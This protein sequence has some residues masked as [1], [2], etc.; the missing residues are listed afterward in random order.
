MKYLLIAMLGITTAFAQS[1]PVTRIKGDKDTSYKISPNLQVPNKQATKINSTTV[2]IETGNGNIIPDPSFEGSSD[3]NV[4]NWGSTGTAGSTRNFWITSDAY[5]GKKAASLTGYHAPH[6]SSFNVE[7]Y[8]DIDTS[9]IPVSTSLNKRVRLKFLSPSGI[10]NF[11]Y[12]LCDR[13]DGTSFNCKEV[14]SGNYNKWLSINSIVASGAVSTGVSV[15][16]SGDT[17]S[18][19]LHSFGFYADDMLLSV[20]DTVDRI[21]EYS[22]QQVIQLQTISTGAI[23]DL[24]NGN[25]VNFVA[26]AGTA[27][28]LNNA[29]NGGVYNVFITD[30]TARTYTFTINKKESGALTV[31]CSPVIAATTASKHA[32]FTFTRIGNNAYCSWAGDL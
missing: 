5:E 22:K 8:S 32:M 11:K 10:T 13:I 29:I 15:K 2:R 24:D 6:S 17:S 14:S 28:T 12:E 25:Q 26:P 18:V 4:S 21:H 9:F 20:N 30:G 23:A 27:I 1:E 3:N 7:F 16:I 31:K 19:G